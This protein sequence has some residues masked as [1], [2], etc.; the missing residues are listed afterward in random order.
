MKTNAGNVI[1]DELVIRAAQPEEA[2][3]LRQFARE[4]FIATYAA[5]NTPENLAIYLEQAFGPQNFQ[6]EFDHPES[7]FYLVLQNEKIIGYYKTNTGTAQ[8]ES[9]QPNSLEIERIYVT[10]TLKGRGIG[11]QMINHA[12]TI[13]RQQHLRYIWLGVW[14]H[15]PKAIAFYEKLGFERIGFHDFQLGDEVQR[16]YIY[17]LR[18]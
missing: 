2:E 3:Q 6:K 11:R 10:G 7:I 14:E 4:H 18:V 1:A 9:D 16:D 17:R 13:C 8:T 5:Q 12:I 15:N